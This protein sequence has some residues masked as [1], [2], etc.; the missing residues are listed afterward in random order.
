VF[1]FQ[2]GR[3]TV[4]LTTLVSSTAGSTTRSDRAR[5]AGLTDELGRR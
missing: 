1:S 2:A 5:Y 4:A 3:V